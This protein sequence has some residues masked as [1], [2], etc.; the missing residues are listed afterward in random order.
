MNDAVWMGRDWRIPVA[1]LFGVAALRWLPYLLWGPQF[2]MDDWLLA[3]NAQQLGAWHTA[4]GLPTRP[5]SHL[6][7]A[8]TFG[9]TQSPRLLLALLG[10]TN[11]AIAFCLWRIAGRWVA[12]AVAIM[13]AVGWLILPVHTATDYWL[14]TL[15]TTIA[16]LLLLV[17]ALLTAHAYATGRSAFLGGMLIVSSVAIYELMLGLAIAAVF[18]I[19]ILERRSLRRVQAAA[20]ITGIAGAAGWI[21]THAVYG[22][23]RGL[24]FEGVWRLN[25]QLGPVTRW[26]ALV[27]LASTS[28]LVVLLAVA[29][30]RERSRRAWMPGRLALAGVAMMVLGLLP[31]LRFPWAVDGLGDRI[32]VVAAIGTAVVWTAL[33]HALPTS[34][35]RKV[36]ALSIALLA[37]A[38]GTSRVMDYREAGRAG[39]VWLKEPV[40]TPFPSARN[41]VYAFCCDGSEVQPHLSAAAAARELAAQSE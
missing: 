36:A 17:G 39:K 20:V 1:L 4:S 27:L 30:S 29:Y 22:I 23:Q 11:V 32:N 15:P 38:S 6:V 40:H 34:K 28:S 24:D 16:L 14:S 25:F 7:Y 37:L 5:G 35:G 2:L 8:A 41:N 9:L 19:P 3:R 33:I 26:S 18:A 31:A 21:A 10:A 13:L 12:S